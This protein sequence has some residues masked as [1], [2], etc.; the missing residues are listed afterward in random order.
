MSLRRCNKR[1][2]RNTRTGKHRTRSSKSQDLFMK[3]FV[4]RIAI[5]MALNL[6]LLVFGF[7]LWIYRFLNLEIPF[8][9]EILSNLFYKIS[10]SE[11]D[12]ANTL[13]TS[14]ISNT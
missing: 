2:C 13:R 4:P 11:V 7:V 10:F 12:Y 8:L 3:N 1:K 9:T 6:N 5:G 14:S